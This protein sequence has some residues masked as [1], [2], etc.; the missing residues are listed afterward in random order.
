MR[1]EE[2]LAHRLLLASGRYAAVSFI[3]DQSRSTADFE[4]AVVDG[5]RGVAEVSQIID[6]EHMATAGA[7]EKVARGHHAGVGLVT[8]VKCQD[9]WWVVPRKS[10]NIRRLVE[11]LDE[12]LAPIEARGT[13]TFFGQGWRRGNDV[14]ALLRLGVEYAA[15]AQFKSP[16]LMI[17]HPSFG[18]VITEAGLADEVRRILGR[19]DNLR[20][21][22]QGQDE[23]HM[24]VYVDS[25]TGVAW[26]AINDL[27]LSP[28]FLVPAEPLTRVTLFAGTRTSGELV[29]WSWDAEDPVWRRALHP[30][31]RAQPPV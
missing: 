3:A 1:R 4:L 22:A 24:M 8:K 26:T 28:D 16:G 2:E 6:A 7:V 15:R 30:G 29:S 11:H 19:T 14:D 23:R 13:T 25:R 12:M 31:L 27:E 10:A 9:D 17:Y 20:K 18:G 21:V 5:R